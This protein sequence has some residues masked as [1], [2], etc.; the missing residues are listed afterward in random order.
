LRGKR[1]RQPKCSRATWLSRRFALGYHSAVIG[2]WR[3]FPAMR[4][5]GCQTE[6]RVCLDV[7]AGRVF[8]RPHQTKFAA[9]LSLAFII[10]KVG[11]RLK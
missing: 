5:R 6:P 8:S 11:L 9:E 2:H 3:L 7:E 10:F 1:I 4:R